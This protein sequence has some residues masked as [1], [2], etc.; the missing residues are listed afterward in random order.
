MTA[1]VWVILI[2]ILMPFSIKK[3]RENTVILKKAHTK[4]NKN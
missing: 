3:N 4:E 2:P 1:Y